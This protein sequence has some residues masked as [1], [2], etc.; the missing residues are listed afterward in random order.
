[1]E[2]SSRGFA[3]NPHFCW[4]SGAVGGTRTPDPLVR[5]K[6]FLGSSLGGAVAG[7]LED[8]EVGAPWTDGIAVLVGQNPGDLVEMSY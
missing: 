2:A 4:E 8:A 6:T 5:S 1:M 7:T 3:N